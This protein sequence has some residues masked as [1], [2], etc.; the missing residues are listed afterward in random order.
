VG[1]LPPPPPSLL[2]PRGRP[3]SPLEVVSF[4]HPQPLGRPGPTSWR[5][6]RLWARHLARAVG[7][8]S[9][10]RDLGHAQRV[11]PPDTPACRALRRLAGPRA[12]VASWT[13]RGNPPVDEERQRC[14][15]FVAPPLC[16]RSS[17]EI[18]RDQACRSGSSELL[19]PGES[20]DRGSLRPL[21]RP[22]LRPALLKSLNPPHHS[23]R[24]LIAEPAPGALSRRA[25]SSSLAPNGRGEIR[26]V[27][28][29]SVPRL[30]P[31]V[32][33]EHQGPSNEGPWSRLQQPTTQRLAPEGQQHS[34]RRPRCRCSQSRRR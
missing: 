15:E 11:F 8:A 16:A 32:A 9:L 27:S 2:R 6:E 33:Q 23:C 14:S 30:V 20:S 34:P 18:T 13:M 22:A 29:S 19:H 1:R 24:H 31:G 4:D 17:V 26:R 25:A 5:S 28:R 3:H 12:T 21:P 7:W 10:H